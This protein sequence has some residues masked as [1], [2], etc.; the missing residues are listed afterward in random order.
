MVLMFSTGGE[1]DSDD[2]GVRCHLGGRTF[3]DCCELH[4]HTHTHVYMYCT[5][6]ITVP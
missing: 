4:A 5:V 3:T 2:C 6:P 1:T